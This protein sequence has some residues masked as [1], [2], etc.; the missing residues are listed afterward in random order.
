[1]RSA[2]VEKPPVCDDEEPR[3][4]RRLVA[5]ERVEAA[6]H[7]HEDL[8]CQ[9]L[10]IGRALAAQVRDDEPG[11][12]DVELVECDRQCHRTTR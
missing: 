10:G 8:R 1:L 7:P 11:I 9:V 4:E 5:L 12:P 3:T 2:L 6:D